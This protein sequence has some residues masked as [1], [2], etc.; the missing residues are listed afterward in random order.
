MSIATC[1]KAW[2]SAGKLSTLCLLNGILL[3][4]RLAAHSIAWT[5][6]AGISLCGALARCDGVHRC[7]PG[8]SA[9]DSTPIVTCMKAWPSVSTLSA[10][11]SMDG[12]LLQPLALS[13]LA[14]GVLSA[15]CS[16][17]RSSEPARGRTAMERQ[18]GTGELEDG[19]EDDCRGARLES[20]T[21]ACS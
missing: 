2:P 13:F 11:C 7:L 15:I 19:A 1:M 9:C 8:F 16:C 4:T 20:V 17:L 12:S 6:V 5:K 3:G 10:L 21:A 18:E 14:S